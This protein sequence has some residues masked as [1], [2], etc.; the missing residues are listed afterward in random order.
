MPFN[1]GMNIIYKISFFVLLFSFTPKV[2]DC[3][4]LKNNSFTYKLGKKDV[5]VVFTDNKHIEYHDDRK[6]I[7]RSAIEWVSD[8]EYYLTIQEATLPDFPFSTGVRLHIKITK[9][10]GDK[11]YYKSTLGTRSWEGR[12][13]RN[14]SG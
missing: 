13:I 1:W 8:C 3:A 2:K 11:V 6:Y 5:L 4:I 9:V 7:I 10:K 14:K 12:M